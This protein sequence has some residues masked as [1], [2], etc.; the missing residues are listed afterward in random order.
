[1]SV[2]HINIYC[3]PSSEPSHRDGSDEGS[4][5]MV[6]M[7]NKKNYPSIIIKYS[8]YFELCLKD[9][10]GM[11]DSVDPNQSWTCTVFSDLYVPI[12]I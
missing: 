1:M 11:A 8:S 7:E 4:Q 9:A 5:H 12:F 2:L 10:D 3:A 6:S